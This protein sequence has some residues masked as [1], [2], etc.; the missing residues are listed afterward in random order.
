LNGW[1]KL[2]N[3]L[4]WNTKGVLLRELRLL[5]GLSLGQLGESEL[6]RH[7]PVEMEQDRGRLV[8][9]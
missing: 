2:R 6:V 7:V 8:L 4:V 1:A 5:R 9:K 3:N